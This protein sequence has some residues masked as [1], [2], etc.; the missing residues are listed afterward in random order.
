MGECER[1]HPSDT[2]DG[3]MLS[4]AV[5]LARLQSLEYTSKNARALLRSIKFRMG[6]EKQTTDTHIHAVLCFHF[7]SRYIILL[8]FRHHS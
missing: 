1:T 8:D 4:E 3:L 7:Y 2:A 5:L 6:L